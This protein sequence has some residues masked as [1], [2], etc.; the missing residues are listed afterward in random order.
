M[1]P[2]KQNILV[3]VIALA[4]IMVMTGR[5]PKASTDDSR[6]KQVKDAASQSA[7]AAKAFDDIMQVPDKAIPRDLIAQAKAVAVFPHV[8]KVAFAAGGEG[9]RGVVSR[10]LGDGWGEPVFFSARGG[11]F[12]AQIG[13][14][15]TDFV[16]LL[17]DDASL[18]ALMKDKF[19]VGAEVGATAGPV[20][21]NLGA[22][23]GTRPGAQILSYSRSRG[24][25]AGA[26]V[27]G[28]VIKPEDDLNMTIYSKT[29]R[30]MLGHPIGADATPAAGLKAFPHALGR[31]S[32]AT[33]ENR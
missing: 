12:G 32:A 20:G 14:S 13:A 27:K 22:G 11:S 7:K 19:E 31:Y 10:H 24:L 5:S 29:A 28:V 8:I 4:A 16:L 1:N 6:E 15:S 18:E 26:N 23:T 33:S 2:E 21:A 3:V 9:G 17:M 25:F 30:E